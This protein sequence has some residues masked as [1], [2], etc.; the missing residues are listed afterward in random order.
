MTRL[1]STYLIS[2]SAVRPDRPVAVSEWIEKDERTQDH[3]EK[4]K[5]E[6]ERNNLSNPMQVN[7]IFKE[8]L[9]L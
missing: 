4:N 8:L 1:W 6:K 9:R 7:T 5:K 3:L 2:I